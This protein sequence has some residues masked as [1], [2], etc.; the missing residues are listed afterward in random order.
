MH[1]GEPCA[2]NLGV[3]QAQNCRLQHFSAADEIEGILAN[4]PLFLLAGWC[5]E[6]IGTIYLCVLLLLGIESMNLYVWVRPGRF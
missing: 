2:Q 3:L 4:K 5:A 6:D 1:S